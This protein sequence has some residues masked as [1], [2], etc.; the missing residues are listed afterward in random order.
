MIRKKKNPVRYLAIWG[1]FST[2]LLYSAIGII[3]ILSFLK[4]KRG[5]ADEGSL[6]VFLDRFLV[7]KVII[8]AI[9]LG[10]I[11]YIIWRI[12]ETVSDPYG[13]GKKFKGIL[14]RSMSALSSIADA[15][16]AFSA[17]Q[18]ISDT[19]GITES[20][21]PTA[22]RE[23]AGRILKENWG[24]E[25]IMMIGILTGIIAVV[26]IGYVFSRNYMERLDIQKLRSWKKNFIHISAWAGHFARGIIL[27]IIGYFYIKTALSKNA[28]F[29]VNTDKAFDFIGD[30]IGHLWFI[31]VAIGTILYGIFM[32]IFGVYYD[33]N[34]D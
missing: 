24:M 17:F 23:V 7:G 15:L 14:R 3:A 13:Y 30:N 29:V 32:F 26:Q 21:E 28:Q 33:A 2:G 16:I 20:G 19:G 10:M 5:G 31:L 8:W 11:A 27:G 4:L 6:L 18:A 34:K 22:H 1:C 12:Y 9:M 25:A